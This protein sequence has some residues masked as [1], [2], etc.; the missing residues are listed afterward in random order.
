MRN[1]AYN[2]RRTCDEI[3][4]TYRFEGSCQN[5]VPEAIIAFLESNSFEDAI[6]TAVSLGG[7]TDTQAAIAGS[8]AEGYYGVPN[9]LKAKCRE[10][11]PELLLQV[12]LRFENLPL[13]EV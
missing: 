5:S 13:N 9:E 1:F 4:P 2:L 10:Y 8:I 6:R 11:L 7:D 3:R 12:L